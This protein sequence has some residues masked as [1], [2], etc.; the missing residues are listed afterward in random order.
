MRGRV[1]A[2]RRT[3]VPSPFPREG[4][5]SI[6]AAIL[7]IVVAR[8]IRGFLLVRRALWVGVKGSVDGVIAPASSDGAHSSCQSSGFNAGRVRFRYASI[9]LSLRH[10]GATRSRSRRSERTQRDRHRAARFGRASS[11]GHGEFVGLFAIRLM[12]M[13]MGS[14]L[15][16][17]HRRESRWLDLRGTEFRP[18]P[19]LE[20]LPAH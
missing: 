9:R 18:R 15:F 20:L 13:G 16:G 12:P 14:P 3:V 6:K 17:D 7:R 10:R 8:S 4:G 2:R 5:L 11:Q 1:F 19:T